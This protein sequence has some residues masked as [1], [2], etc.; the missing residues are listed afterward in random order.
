M[1]GLKQQPSWLSLPSFVSW[2]WH[3]MVRRVPVVSRVSCPSACPACSPM[4]WVGSRKGPGTVWVLLRNNE[5]YPCYL[6]CFQQKSKPQAHASY[7]EE[8]QLHSSQNQIICEV[9]HP[10]TLCVLKFSLDEYLEQNVKDGGEGRQLHLSD[11]VFC[12][13]VLY[14][15]EVP[16]NDVLKFSLG[17]HRW[18]LPGSRQWVR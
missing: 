12:Q 13:S 6:H 4:A 14:S 1:H 15:V 8:K 9:P 17:T 2:A 11:K 10:K 5:T 16:L 7:C 18:L 3:H